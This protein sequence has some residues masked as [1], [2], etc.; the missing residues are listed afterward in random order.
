MRTNEYNWRYSKEILSFRDGVELDELFKSYNSYKLTEIYSFGEYKLNSVLIEDVN[1]KYQNS[2]T[3]FGGYVLTS[4]NKAYYVFGPYVSLKEIRE[5]LKQ[6]IPN[7][8]IKEY[9]KSNLTSIAHYITKLKDNFTLIHNLTLF[10][11]TFNREELKNYLKTFY[12][13]KRTKELIDKILNY[14]KQYPKLREYGT[15]FDLSVIYIASLLKNLKTFEE[16][17]KDIFFYFYHENIKIFGVLKPIQKEKIQLALVYLILKGYKIYKRYDNDAITE[18]FKEIIGKIA[19]FIKHEKIEETLHKIIDNITYEK[20]KE[21]V[22]QINNIISANKKINISF[23]KLLVELAINLEKF[24]ETNVNKEIKIKYDLNNENIRQIIKLIETEKLEEEYKKATSIEKHTEDED[25]KEK[26]EPE[27][28]LLFTRSEIDYELSEDV[29]KE[30]EEFVNS[31][32]KANIN[33]YPIT[34]ILYSR[35][36]KAKF[37]FSSN[38]NFIQYLASKESNYKN[39]K[40]L[41]FDE[42]INQLF[43]LDKL[44]KLEYKLRKIVMSSE[45]VHL[46]FESIHFEREYP[47]K[48]EGL[49]RRKGRII[50]HERNGILYFTFETM[51]KSLVGISAISKNEYFTIANVNSKDGILTIS[52][53]SENFNYDILLYDVSII[54]KKKS[55][56]VINFENY[57]NSY[58]DDNLNAVVEF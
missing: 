22:K 45:I 20:I 3:F 1:Q 12:F 56:F 40:F 7:I 23:D 52:K 36:L 19:K 31:I 41:T 27:D 18:I 29:L 24:Y 9:K 38:S 35:I 44:K 2:Y 17:L 26:E 39:Y 50:I 16:I 46:D 53:T 43:E 57:Q 13:D 30:I 51:E 5:T 25:E 49:E 33:I 47:K 42:L 55:N 37:Y 48:L 58:L 54:L 4:K 21:L 8:R 15:N 10:F 14:V 32:Y 28:Y 6:D 11:L 34:K